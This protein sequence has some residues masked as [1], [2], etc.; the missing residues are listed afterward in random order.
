MKKITHDQYV[1]WILLNRPDYEVLEYYIDSNTKILHRHK[2]SGGEWLCSPEKFKMGTSYPPLSRNNKSPV[3]ISH[4]QYV[5]WVNHNRPDFC[6]IGE[7]KNTNT[8]ILHRHKESGVEWLCS[9]EKFKKGHG[10][11]E[12]SR[13]PRMTNLEYVQYI[14]QNNIQIEPLERFRTK[15]KPIK[16]K[17]LISNDVFYISPIR[18]LTNN[19]FK[20]V[21]KIN[22]T[23]SYKQ[24]LSVNY[25]S[26]LITEP[27]VTSRTKINHIDVKS[28]SCWYVK[29]NNVISGQRHPIEQLSGVSR[30]SVMWLDKMEQDNQI[31]IQHKL[32][33]GEYVV[34]GVGRV[35]GYCA[36]TNTVFEFHG[37]FWHGNPDIFDPNE[38]NPVTKQ[39]FGYLYNTTLLREQKILDRGYNLITIWEREFLDT[40][41]ENYNE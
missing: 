25:P 10:P 9:P 13:C 39:K 37:D 12:L 27:Y 34:T 41:K 24:W 40:L 22:D 31:H 38:I 23:S 5:E 30:V 2:E 33:G 28:G 26:L 6:I 1:A 11:T 7:Y 14:K 35:D 18:V 20:Y 32:K 4:Q 8:K 16:H 15:T 29:P 19:K 21:R 17:C 36:E 3:K